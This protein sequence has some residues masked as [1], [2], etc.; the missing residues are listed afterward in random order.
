MFFFYKILVKTNYIGL[1]RLTVSDSYKPKVILLLVY[2]IC[3]C[4]AIC[5]VYL[6]TT[7]LYEGT[8]FDIIGTS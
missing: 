4:L 3:I 7:N 8:G 6:L 1:K 5:S 2:P